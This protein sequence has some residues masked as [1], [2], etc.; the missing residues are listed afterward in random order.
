M[1]KIIALLLALATVFAFAACGNNAST[2]P[3]TTEAKVEVPESA[4]V[5]L[6]T[7]WNSYAEEEKFFAMGGSYD[8][9]ET[10]NNMVD[11]APGKY[12]L[13]N[14]GMTTSLMAPADQLANITD[15]A[16]LMNGMMAN[17]FTGAAFRVTDAAAFAEAM[18]T[19]I[20]SAQWICG[21]PEKLL[22][23]IV[24]GEYVVAA[25]GLADQL[26]NFASK[27]SAAYPDAE[28]KYN[29]AIAG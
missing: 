7:V 13:A 17:H 21:Q 8:E 28:V 5:I 27:L 29:E 18:H 1:K 12:D 14:E 15:A 26:D 19:S 2:T 23:V 6:E 10:K 25:F 3:T 4:L 9:D 24:G 11:G 16:S 20:A 22:V